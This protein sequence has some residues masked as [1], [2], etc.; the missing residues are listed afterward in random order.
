MPF[1]LHTYRKPVALRFSLRRAHGCMGW[2][3]HGAVVW[4]PL[5]CKSDMASMCGR[6]IRAGLVCV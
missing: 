4:L 5:E 6:K 2:R 3:L 1:G